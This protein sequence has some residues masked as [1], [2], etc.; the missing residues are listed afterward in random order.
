MTRVLIIDPQFEKEPDVERAVA[1]PNVTFEI[2]RPT[3][4]GVPAEALRRAD[5]V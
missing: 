4:A 5:A 1:G 2:I 3:A